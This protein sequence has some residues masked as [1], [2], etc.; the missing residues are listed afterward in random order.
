MAEVEVKVIENEKIKEL[1]AKDL[2]L[3][4]S[5]TQDAGRKTV[6]QV[7]KSSLVRQVTQIFEGSTG[8]SRRGFIA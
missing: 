6:S 3:G 2:L 4:T 7:P 1:R 5:L 8:S